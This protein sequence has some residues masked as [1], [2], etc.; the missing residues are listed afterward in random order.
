MNKERLQTLAGEVCKSRR[1]HPRETLG[2]FV[3]AAPMLDKAGAQ[4]LQI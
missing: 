2:G 4:A 1:H 3:M